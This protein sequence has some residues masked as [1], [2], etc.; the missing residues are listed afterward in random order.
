MDGDP[1]QLIQRALE[2]LQ[3]ETDEHRALSDKQT[4]E[5]ADLR[6][7]ERRLREQLRASQ[8]KIAEKDEELKK[9]NK[10]LEQR[11]QELESLRASSEKARAELARILDGLGRAADAGNSSGQR[12]TD[13]ETDIKPEEDNQAKLLCSFNVIVSSRDQ[14]VRRPRTR[15]PASASANL[16]TTSTLRTTNCTTCRAFSSK[17]LE[18]P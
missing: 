16:N 2:K 17:L 6:R 1:R 9:K 3:Q 13:I 11:E 8:A 10:K 4:R 5:N 14:R 18:R 7:T 12:Q 15:V